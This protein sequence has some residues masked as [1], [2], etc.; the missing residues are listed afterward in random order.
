M[1]SAQDNQNSQNNQNNNQNNQN[2]QGHQD[3]S[4]VQNSQ[5]SQPQSGG[6]SGSTAAQRLAQAILEPE[7]KE[8]NEEKEKL[9]SPQNQASQNQEVSQNDT[10]AQGNESAQNTPNNQS[11]VASN[12]QNVDP[13]QKLIGMVKG[14]EGEVD[15]IKIKQMF[16]VVKSKLANEALQ[17]LV[18]TGRQQG[19]TDTQL[20][21]FLLALDKEI[22]LGTIDEEFFNQITQ[23][24]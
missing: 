14:K 16:V 23:N 3:V 1:D 7:K 12:S 24:G 22:E 6:T 8:E 17:V 13:L 20:L 21:K 5:P 4:S 9:A 2:G 10:S 19:L 15:P 11:N 18:D